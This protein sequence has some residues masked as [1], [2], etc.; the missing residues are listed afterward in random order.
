[1]HFRDYSSAR[2]Q[3]YIVFGG[4]AMLAPALVCAAMLSLAWF[5]VFDLS[6]P[7]SPGC[8]H[9][10]ASPWGN[11]VSVFDWPIAF[12]SLAY[13]A[14]AT[15]AWLMST[16]AI[17]VYVLFMLRAGAIV[18]AACV[19]LTIA[20][21]SLCVYWLILHIANLAFWLFAELTGRRSRMSAGESHQNLAPL[22][23]SVTFVATFALVSALLMVAV[24]E[25]EQ[26]NEA[27]YLAADAKTSE[28]KALT[29]SAAQLD[30]AANATVSEN[31]SLQKSVVATEPNDRHLY[32]LGSE[33]APLQIVVYLDYQCAE[34]AEIDGKLQELYRRHGRELSICVRHYPRSTDCNYSQRVNLHPNACQAAKA[35]EAAGTLRGTTGFWQMHR[36]LFERRGTFTRQELEGALRN[37]QYEDIPEFMATMESPEILR[38]ILADI[39]EAKSLGIKERPLVMLNGEPLGDN[40]PA[41]RLLAEIQ[42]RLEQLAGS[43]GSNTDWLPALAGEEADTETFSKQLQASAIAATV[44]VVNGDRNSVGSGVIVSARPPF[45]YVLTAHHVIAGAKTIEVDLF[46]S[47]FYPRPSQRLLDAHVIATSPRIDAALLR[48]TSKQAGLAAVQLSRQSAGSNQ[49]PFSALGAGCTI[50]GA[51]TCQVERVIASKMVRREAKQDASLVWEVQSESAKGRSGGPLFDSE[52]RLIGIASGRSEGRGYYSHIVEIQKFLSDSSARWALNENTVPVNE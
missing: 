30:T 40:E 8:S 34:S 7:M 20:G 25:H 5:G 26:R 47:L 22:K 15:V 14:A 41:E 45:V 52:G 37:Q 6:E 48:L 46:S 9:A 3:G 51:P 10:L 13:I 21:D 12:L 50:E 29:R 38:S 31:V 24:S 28:K 23:G 11:V 39:V 17:A 16:G 44:R 32:R 43:Q 35:V 33:N 19:S 1:M 42:V 27:H 4:L 49:L 2:R 18:S 36:W